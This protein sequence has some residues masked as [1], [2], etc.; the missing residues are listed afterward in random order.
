MY[1]YPLTNITVY[2]YVYML[3]L[4]AVSRD[5]KVWREDDHF[6]DVIMSAIAS[7][8]TS[9]TIVYLTIYSGGDERK[10][11]SSASLPFVRGIRRWPGI[12]PHK[13]PVTR[14]MFPFDDIMNGLVPKALN[15]SNNCMYLFLFK[16]FWHDIFM[17]KALIYGNSIRSG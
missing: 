8:T 1:V 17:K 14:K 16:Y 13:G 4:T 11:Q 5:G 6:S 9:L 7:Q 10:H 15:I 2:T 12:S 3:T